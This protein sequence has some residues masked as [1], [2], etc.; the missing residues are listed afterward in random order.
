MLAGVGAGMEAYLRR[1]EE[2]ETSGAGA[3]S[4][5]AEEVDAGGIHTLPAEDTVRIVV[6]KYSIQRV[7]LLPQRSVA[8]PMTLPPTSMSS[9]SSVSLLALVDLS[10]CNPL[11]FQMHR[12]AAVFFTHFRHKNAAPRQRSSFVL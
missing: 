2:G 8:V 9:T 11:P 12:K 7:A 1:T 3:H 10:L 5:V 4:A 6:E